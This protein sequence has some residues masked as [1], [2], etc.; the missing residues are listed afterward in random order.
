MTQVS[1]TISSSAAPPIPATRSM[2]LFVARFTNRLE[3]P[4]TGFRCKRLPRAS[5]PDPDQRAWVER[6]RD[7]LRASL[8][9]QPGPELNQ[10]LL[11]FMG[12]YAQFGTQPR[13]MLAKVA[14]YAE[15]VGGLPTWAVDEARKAFMR[16]GWKSLWSGRGCP[17]AADLVAECRHILL[18]YETELAR[19][20]GVLEAELYETGA[21]EDERKE[22]LAHVDD[23]LAELRAGDN[24]ITERTEE[25]IC[26]ERASMAR[27]NERFRARERVQAEA[28]GRGQAMWGRLPISDELARRIGAR[29]PMPAEDEE[30]VH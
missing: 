24:P 6:R 28:S 30:E 23:V 26:V 29:V 10:V 12:G 22:V 16:P 5:A 7:D 21:S 19:I 27:A 18:P 15:A 17:E 9:A 1:S 13:E 25:E 14:I 3:D 20:E 11:K 8:A 2:D 4:P